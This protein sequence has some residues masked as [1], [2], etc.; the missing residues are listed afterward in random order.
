[1]KRTFDRSAVNPEFEKRRSPVPERRSFFR[2]RVIAGCKDLSILLRRGNAHFFGALFPKIPGH[3]LHV[4]DVVNFIDNFGSQESLDD[5]FEGDD[6]REGAILIENGCNV[7]PVC[8]HIIEEDREVLR[9]RDGV[10]GASEVR[11]RLV[12]LALGMGLKEFDL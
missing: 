12:S 5:V 10:D 11:K 4:V 6:S 9:S 7:N 8:D 2:E 3:L 1:M